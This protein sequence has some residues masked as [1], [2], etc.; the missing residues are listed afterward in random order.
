MRLLGMLLT[1]FSILVEMGKVKLFNDY[2]LVQCKPISNDST[3]VNF[4]TIFKV[5]WLTGR[6][7]SFFR[8]LHPIGVKSTLVFP[9]AP[10]SDLEYGS[11]SHIIFVAD[12]TSLCEKPKYFGTRIKLWPKTWFPIGRTNGKWVVSLN[13]QPTKQAAKVVFSPKS[14]Q[15]LPFILM[16][17]K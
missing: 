12:D 9:K 1:V 15:I 14:E 10:C 17:L 4:L 7:E 16:V 11:K 6:N 5:I 13:Q 3:L 2:F 8:V